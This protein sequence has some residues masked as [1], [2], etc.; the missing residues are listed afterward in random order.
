MSGVNRRATFLS[1]SE[2]SLPPESKKV[3]KGKRG[4]LRAALA[5]PVPLPAL[6][7]SLP[8]YIEHVRDDDSQKTG[9]E[10]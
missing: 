1:E 4:S 9:A 7:L 3:K 10:G 8:P 5:V 2:G 6:P